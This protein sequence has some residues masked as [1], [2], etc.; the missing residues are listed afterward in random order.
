MLAIFE[1]LDVSVIHIFPNLFARSWIV[2]HE[3]AF[4]LDIVRRPKPTGYGVLVKSRLL[5]REMSFLTK[6]LLLTFPL[7]L[8]PPH[9]LLLRTI[10]LSSRLRPLL[11]SLQ[12][13]LT[14]T[15]LDRLSESPLL[16]F[17]RYPRGFRRYLL[18]WELLL[19]WEKC[20]PIYQRT[21]QFLL[22][23]FLC[24]LRILLLSPLNLSMILFL[25]RYHHPMILIRS[26]VLEPFQNFIATLYLFILHRS[27]LLPNRIHA[28]GFLLYLRNLK[29]FI[30]P[31]ILS[32]SRSGKKRC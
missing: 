28:L 3:S 13:Q 30:K 6:I 12:C 1:C 31:L 32:T 27:G 7:C 11:H 15:V 19:Q 17:H 20:I 29:R 9:L 22:R 18:Q 14:L 26:C 24:L 23:R 4:L 8:N 25:L 2:R 16:G 21:R 5:W 10:P